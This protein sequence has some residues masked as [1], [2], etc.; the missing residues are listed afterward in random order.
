MASRQ[1][2]DSDAKYQTTEREARIVRDASGRVG[3]TDHAIHRFRQRTPHDCRV[4]I[5]E[6]WRRGEELQHP[7]VAGSLDQPEPES[8]RVYRHSDG[9][10]VV[11]I[12]VESHAPDVGLRDDRAERVAATTCKIR[13]F[14][15]APVRAYLRSHGPHGGSSR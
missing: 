6:A 11:F 4:T 12:V 5:R 1:T 2:Q 9:W 3:L 8:A 15:H 14:D 13:T 7:S 10:G